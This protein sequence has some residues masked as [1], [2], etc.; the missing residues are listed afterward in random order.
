MNIYECGLEECG[1]EPLEDEKHYKWIDDHIKT[2]VG[3]TEEQVDF[4]IKLLKKQEVN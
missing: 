2:D 4:L 3:L 1:C